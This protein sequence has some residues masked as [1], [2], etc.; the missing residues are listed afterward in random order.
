M[1][2]ASERR[3]DLNRPL[4]TSAFNPIDPQPSRTDTSQLQPKQHPEDATPMTPEEAAKEALAIEEAMNSISVRQAMR[5]L[6]RQLGESLSSSDDED[7]DHSE[8][9]EIKTDPPDDMK[10]QPLR[11]ATPTRPY[12]I[13]VS[14]PS[15]NARADQTAVS[16][17]ASL[18]VKTTT[19]T[20][21]T[22]T[23]DDS[24]VTDMELRIQISELLS[25]SPSGEE[26]SVSYSSWTPSVSPDPVSGFG[27]SP[28]PSPLLP[29][30]SCRRLQ[31]GSPTWAW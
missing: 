16:S 24:Q 26:H 12:S 18:S 11:S 30:L 7:D 2:T 15:E 8:M 10:E 4:V 3:A 1:E 21:T 6:S 27:R 22:T 28:S 25:I 19:T 9:L 31:E 20:T 23:T 17:N 13:S 14:A 5:T 29:I